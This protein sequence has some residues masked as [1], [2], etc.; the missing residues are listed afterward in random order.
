MAEPVI[1]LF[2]PVGEPFGGTVGKTLVAGEGWFV[3]EALMPDGRPALVI[4]EGTLADMLPAD[5]CDEY[6]MRV[7]VFASADERSSYAADRGW[8]R[9]SSGGPHTLLGHLAVTRGEVFTQAEVLCTI[10]L[11]WILS[12]S[13]EASRAFDQLLGI[14]G[15]LEWQSEDLLSG[16]D[17]RP[18]LVGRAAV[19]GPPTVIVEAKLAALLDE[20]Q[21]RAYQRGGS[22]VVVLVPQ[23]RVGSARSKLEQWHLI[24]PVVSWEQVIAEVEAA[25]PFG[26]VSAEIGAAD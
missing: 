25:V 15:S 14:D 24:I 5:E 6:E 13:S 10:S 16:V 21:L 11:A 8:A 23:V 17:G 3:A 1:E 19:G 26:P 4:D 18:D 22:R 20:T 12:C 9:R 7:L 2:G